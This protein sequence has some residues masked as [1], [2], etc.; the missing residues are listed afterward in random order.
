MG[1]DH[2]GFHFEDG[3]VQANS[4]CKGASDRLV[5][6]RKRRC[7]QRLT[8]ASR[9]A[10][11]ALSRVDSRL[12]VVVGFFTLERVPVA[13]IGKPAIPGANKSVFCCRI[14]YL[15]REYCEDSEGDDIQHPKCRPRKSPL[16]RSICHPTPMPRLQEKYPC[17]THRRRGVSED[18]LALIMQAIVSPV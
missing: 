18:K 16:K 4:V 10:L 6:P 5:G 1:V 9:R 11:V 15:G 2:F 12:E 17:S 7:G 3:I 13:H 14:G 8:H